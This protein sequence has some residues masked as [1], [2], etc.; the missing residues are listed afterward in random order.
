MIFLCVFPPCHMYQEPANCPDHVWA[1]I[2]VTVIEGTVYR[3]WECE[4]CT[5]WTNEP[6]E[7]DRR[8][9]REDTAVSK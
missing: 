1:S 5:A 8:V 9:P 6:L 4:R 2:G 3:I 7:Q